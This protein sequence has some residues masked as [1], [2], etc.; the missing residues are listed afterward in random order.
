MK[1]KVAVIAIGLMVAGVGSVWA[2]YTPASQVFQDGEQQFLARLNEQQR[3]AYRDQT[4]QILI[5]GRQ[6]L[7]RIAMYV[8]YADAQKIVDAEFQYEIGKLKQEIL[9]GSEGPVGQQYP[10]YQQPGQYQ[11][12]QRYQQGPVYQQRP[13]Y[14]APRPQQSTRYSS[15]SG[16]GIGQVV[17]VLANLAQ[18]TK[19]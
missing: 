10:V 7:E 16:N 9:R 15:G 18:Y 3:I 13:Q 19:R 17:Q 5:E 2:D 14:Q 11:Q 1:I 6:R 12:P 4:Q 8:S